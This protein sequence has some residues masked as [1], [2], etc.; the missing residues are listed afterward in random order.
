N[1]RVP[2][3]ATSAVKRR[4]DKLLGGDGE[5]APFAV[6]AS[7]RRTEPAVGGVAWGPQEED[8]ARRFYHSGVRGERLPPVAPVSG[9]ASGQS[10]TE[11]ICWRS[12]QAR[13]A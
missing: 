5:V 3:L 11:P 1:Y 8:A 12:R 13:A 4:R 10:S 9:L 6:R 2:G 7:V